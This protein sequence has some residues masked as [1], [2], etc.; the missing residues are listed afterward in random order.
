[1]ITIEILPL[2]DTLEKEFDVK[3]KFYEVFEYKIELYCSE[4]NHVKFF[5][6]KKY[7]HDNISLLLDVNI[8]NEYKRLVTLYFKKKVNVIDN[9]LR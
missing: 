1:M 2:L 5:K 8:D 9:R 3:T 6:M 4:F 7:L